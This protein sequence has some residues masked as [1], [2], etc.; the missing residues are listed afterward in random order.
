MLEKIK[1]EYKRF[2]NREFKKLFGNYELFDEVNIWSDIWK[3]YYYNNKSDIEQKFTDLLKNLDD[4]SIKTAKELFERNVF[5]LPSQ[6]YNRNFLYKKEDFFNEDE[7]REQK[8]VYV[9]D[10]N[11]YKFPKNIYYEIAIFKYGQGIKLLPKDILNK[12]SQKDFIDG[13]AFWGDSALI[14]KEFTK[15]KIYS[16]E[17]DNVK[18]EGLKETIKINNLENSIIPVKFGLNDKKSQIELFETPFCMSPVKD[19]SVGN[20]PTYIETVTIDD[21]VEENNLNVGLIKLDIE[22]HELETI[23]GGL[24]S[25]TTHKPVLLISIYHHPKD[26][27]NIKPLIESLGLDYKFM[28]RKLNYCSL[29]DETMLIGYCEN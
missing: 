9:I 2:I 28:I 23:K 14:F 16:F 29:T 21:F 22:G 26:F 19:V 10:K 25:I 4:T 20:N 12:I 11:K 17:P 15:S 24:N 18:Y 27:F 7:L 8:T 3:E 1:K 13:G 5:M 6:K